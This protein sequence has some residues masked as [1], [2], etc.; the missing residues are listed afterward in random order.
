MFNRQIAL[1]EKEVVSQCSCCGNIQTLPPTIDAKHYI[2][3]PKYLDGFKIGLEKIYFDCCLSVCDKCYNFGITDLDSLIFKKFNNKQIQNILLSNKDKIEK[4]LI[5]SN[6]IYKNSIQTTLEL[7][8]YYDFNKS[9]SAEVK[10]IRKQL[11]KLYK[12]ELKEKRTQRDAMFMLIELYRRDSQ[13]EISQKLISKA[14]INASIVEKEW[15]DKQSSLCVSCD[16][17]R[18]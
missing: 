6:I 9:N 2:D 16:S 12:K 10:S 15:L 13:F 14:I 17:N 18:H 8:W 11:I 5:V 4:A 7:Y 3:L 1:R